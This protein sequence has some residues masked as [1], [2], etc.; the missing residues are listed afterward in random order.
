MARIQCHHHLAEHCS[1]N[2]N[3]MGRYAKEAKEKQH[4]K[5]KARGKVTHCS[6]RIRG[7]GKKKGPTSVFTS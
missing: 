1:H 5:E 6:Q 3:C 4:V 2:T 7:S